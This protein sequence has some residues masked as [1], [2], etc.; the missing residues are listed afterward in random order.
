MINQNEL[1]IG[2]WVK[3]EDGRFIHIHDGFG[4]DHFRQFYPIELSPEILEQ[5]GLTITSSYH[6]EGPL[7]DIVNNN[8][9]TRSC[10]KISICPLYH[11]VDL[12]TIGSNFV[13]FHEIKYLH[14]LQNLIHS[15]TGE[16]LPINL[17][18]TQE[19]N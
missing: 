3:E 19:K 10:E 13:R 16:E 12:I 2:N 8:W 4:I 14:Q 7:F 1:R 17:I 15:L 11:F 6:P 18:H 5:C 9:P